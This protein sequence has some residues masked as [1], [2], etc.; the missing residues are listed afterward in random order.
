MSAFT[1]LALLATPGTPLL[2]RSV[3]NP[4]QM[5]TTLPL[6]SCSDLASFSWMLFSPPI[7]QYDLTWCATAIPALAGSLRERSV[8]RNSILSFSSP[9]LTILGAGSGTAE[10]GRVGATSWVE[11]EVLRGLC[12]AAGGGEMEE[13]AGSEVRVELD[14]PAGGRVTLKGLFASGSSSSDSESGS[15][16]SLGL[17]ASGTP[18]SELDWSASASLGGDGFDGGAMGATGTDLAAIGIGIS[19]IGTGESC[20]RWGFSTGGLM[21]SSALA[22]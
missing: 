3:T 16:T 21:T 13:S 22:G 12:G 11:D 20:L 19:R 5:K 7:L 18:S 15:R 4:A 9:R 17:L 2:I 1:S 14:G 8:W 6:T 10:V